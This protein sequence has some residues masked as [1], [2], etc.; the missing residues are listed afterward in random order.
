MGDVFLENL[1]GLTTTKIYQSDEFKHQE[2][3]KQGEIFRKI[4]MRVLTMQLNSI[5]IMD[6]VAYGGA[7]IGVILATTQFRAGNVSLAGSL[8][9][10]LLAADFF[11]PHAHVRILLSYCHE[12]NGSQ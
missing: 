3:N 11:S 12:W 5:F 6:L 7:A 4:T 8:M 9:I 1:Q 2:M 10:I